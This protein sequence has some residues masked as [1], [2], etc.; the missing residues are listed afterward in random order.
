[1]FDYEKSEERVAGYLARLVRGAV[2]GI[3]NAGNIAPDKGRQIP[4]GALFRLFRK[5]TFLQKRRGG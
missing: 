1:M 2:V 4:R 5:R 3:G